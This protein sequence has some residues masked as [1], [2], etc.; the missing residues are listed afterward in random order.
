MYYMKYQPN[1][2][3]FFLKFNV[4][5]FKKLFHFPRKQLILATIKINFSFSQRY[6]K[7]P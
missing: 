1:I 6:S 7:Y 3:I 4:G 2:R 5:F